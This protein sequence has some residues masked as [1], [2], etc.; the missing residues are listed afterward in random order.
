MAVSI[1]FQASSLEMG[2]KKISARSLGV[3]C[4]PLASSP[5]LKSKDLRGP[6]LRR[7]ATQFAFFGSGLASLEIPESRA[8]SLP[9]PIRHSVK[10][11]AGWQRRFLDWLY[12]GDMS[13]T[14]CL[15]C[16]IPSRTQFCDC[17]QSLLDAVSRPFF[18]AA[19]KK[20]KAENRRPARGDDPRESN[21]NPPGRSG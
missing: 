19:H 8:R 10:L 2:A 4:N 3:G 13:H 12:R 18:V 21:G 6:L 14:G 7:C 11:F 9:V 16:G 5:A 15:N 1:P 20:W 17:C